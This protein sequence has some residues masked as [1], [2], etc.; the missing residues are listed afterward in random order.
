M[1]CIVHGVAKRQPQ[2]G[3][4]M[5]KQKLLDST[6]VYTNQNNYLQEQFG[7]ICQACT[8]LIALLPLLV[9]GPMETLILEQK[10]AGMNVHYSIIRYCHNNKKI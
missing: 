4:D 3:K 2:I 10:D 5:E 1:D 6:T 7:N 9:I 8:R